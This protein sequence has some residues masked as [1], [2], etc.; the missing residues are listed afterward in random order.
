MDGWNEYRERHKNYNLKETYDIVQNK[1]VCPDPGR[2]QE[3]REV[4]EIK[5][6]WE[7][8]RNLKHLLAKSY[9]TKTS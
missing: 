4:L 7:Q 1:L 5:T 3:L 8:R 6:L 9:K 2:H